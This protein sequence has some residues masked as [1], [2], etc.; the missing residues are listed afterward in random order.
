MDLIIR[1]ALILR[2][3]EVSLVDIGIRRRRH[4]CHRA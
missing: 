3:A 1:N 2:D 4:L